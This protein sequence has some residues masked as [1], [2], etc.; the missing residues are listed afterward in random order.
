LLQYLGTLA[1]DEFQLASLSKD[2]EVNGG[3]SG[4]NAPTSP[5]VCS[6][7]GSQGLGAVLQVGDCAPFSCSSCQVQQT[8]DAALGLCQGL[9]LFSSPNSTLPTT[10]PQA[11]T[12]AWVIAVAVVVPVVV[13]LSVAVAL[14]VIYV[15]RGGMARS[16]KIGNERLRDKQMH[17]MH[18]TAD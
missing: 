8:C 17:A 16:D 14:L 18:A 13:L 6:A 11:G 7:E 2:C 4:T 15:R 3:V 12:E 9:A 1:L 5:A 10:V